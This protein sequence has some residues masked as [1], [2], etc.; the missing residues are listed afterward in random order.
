MGGGRGGSGPERRRSRAA[1]RWREMLV[2]EREA[3]ALYSGLAESETGERAEILRELAEVEL[4]SARIFRL[5]RFN[6]SVA[7]TLPRVEFFVSMD[8]PDIM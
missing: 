5:P 7:S 1:R 8:L 2:A 4:R 6:S 3:A